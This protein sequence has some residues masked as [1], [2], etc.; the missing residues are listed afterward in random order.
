MDGAP[1]QPVC[2]SA[3]FGLE[4]TLEL[5]GVKLHVL[6]NSRARLRVVKADL[7]EASPFDV[8]RFARN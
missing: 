5:A 2:P 7:D 1:V 6:I 4:A 3:G 8:D